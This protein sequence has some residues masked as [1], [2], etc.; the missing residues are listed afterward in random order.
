MPGVSTR[1]IRPDA[2]VCPT[3]GA[4]LPST[5]TSRSSKANRQVE[6]AVPQPGCASTGRNCTSTTT[7]RTPSVA[8]VVYVLDVLDR[9]F[10]AHLPLVHGGSH[11][12]VQRGDQPY[13]EDV[14]DMGQELL[15]SLAVVDHVAALRE[16][17]HGRLHE[18]QV[19]LPRARQ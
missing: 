18:H 10:A 5:S 1:C 4:G 8:L 14:P 6:G 17:A 13:L 11:A 15:P 7:P 16:L 3:T 12:A 9:G 19:A 2:K